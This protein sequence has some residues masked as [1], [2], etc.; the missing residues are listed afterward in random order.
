MFFNLLYLKTLS[1]IATN[2]SVQI[3]KRFEAILHCVS[4]NLF[5]CLQTAS[6]T[7]VKND[8]QIHADHFS[9]SGFV[10]TNCLTDAQPR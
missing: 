7:F 10:S 4:L 6:K 5:A 9:T 8:G 2:Y 3:Y 1:L